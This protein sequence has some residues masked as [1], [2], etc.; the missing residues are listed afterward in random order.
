VAADT[1]FELR[2]YWMIRGKNLGLLCEQR[3]RKS[4]KNDTCYHEDSAHVTPPQKI[5]LI[6]GGEKIT[7]G[8]VVM[9]AAEIFVPF[10]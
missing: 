6:C 4:A 2:R 9:F 8:G 5:L 1:F 10:L 3:K 7:H